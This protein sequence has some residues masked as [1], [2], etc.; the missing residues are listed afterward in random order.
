M[1]FVQCSSTLPPQDKIQ[2]P[3]LVT[4]VSTCGSNNTQ[5]P[6]KCDKN[7]ASLVE[8]TE[9]NTNNSESKDVVST[10]ITPVDLAIKQTNLM[11]KER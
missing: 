3:A 8:N 10:N 7:T 9:H 6:N 2:H 5:E 11:E 1:H 4:D